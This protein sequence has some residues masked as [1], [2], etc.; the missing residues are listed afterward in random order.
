MEQWPREWTAGEFRAALAASLLHL[1]AVRHRKTAKT[2]WA[3]VQLPNDARLNP[4]LASSA[5][6]AWVHDSY[7]SSSTKRR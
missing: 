4:T 1:K 7:S 6:V 2:Q 5:G 3:Y